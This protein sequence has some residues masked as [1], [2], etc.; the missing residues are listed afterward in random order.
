MTAIR[1]S[2][3]NPPPAST[4]PVEQRDDPDYSVPR[5]SA[6][7]IQVAPYKVG[8]VVCTLD[9]GRVRKALIVRVGV[10]SVYSVKYIPMY[11]MWFASL[12]DGEWIRTEHHGYPGYIKAG[13]ARKGMQDG[14][15]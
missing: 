14:E 13:Y 5:D 6:H 10:Q 11:V 2:F 12:R 15:V 8:D 4:E 3:T 9:R 7:I 1:T